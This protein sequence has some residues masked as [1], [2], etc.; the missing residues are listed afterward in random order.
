MI[1]F[2][3][4]TLKINDKIDS[5]RNQADYIIITDYPI[6]IE[7]LQKYEHQLVYIFLTSIR[8]SLNDLQLD[9]RGAKIR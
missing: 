5:N 8:L 2:F 9:S 3:F 4:A 6:R 1:W 7:N